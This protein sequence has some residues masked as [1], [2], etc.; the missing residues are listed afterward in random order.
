MSY[1]QTQKLAKIQINPAH[2]SSNIKQSKQIGKSNKN[3]TI[4]ALRPKPK[5]TVSKTIK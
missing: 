1:Q 4:K 2:T 5:V 3:Q